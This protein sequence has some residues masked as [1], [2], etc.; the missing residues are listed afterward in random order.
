MTN[1]TEDFAS[2]IQLKPVEPSETNATPKMQHPRP[3][4]SAKSERLVAKAWSEGKFEDEVR[5]KDVFQF[6]QFALRLLCELADANLAA[7]KPKR[8]R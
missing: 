6:K 4:I 8:P 1:P 7:A 3:S 2:S 5:P